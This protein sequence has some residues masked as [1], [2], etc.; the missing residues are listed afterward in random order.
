M[1]A[2]NPR[3]YH[4]TDGSSGQLRRALLYFSGW[5]FPADTLGVS[6]PGY[7]VYVVWDYT[8]SGED[9][10]DPDSLVADYDEV[11][12]VAWSFG[13]R[14][15]ADYLTGCRA[16]VTRTIAVNG[17]EAHVDDGRGIPH[18]IFDG[19]LRGLSAQT[20]Y[21]FMQRA[22]GSS[23]A[24]REYFNQIKP[25]VRE[26]DMESLGTELALFGRT[27]PLAGGYSWSVVLIGE[28]DRIFPPDNQRRAWAANTDVRTLPGADHYIPFGEIRRHIVDK[29]LVCSR[30]SNAAATYPGHSS[31]QKYVSDRLK[32][33]LEN[34]GTPHVPAVIEIGAGNSPVFGDGYDAISHKSLE[35]W[36]IA[37]IDPSRFPAGTKVSQTDAEIHIADIPDCSADL[38]VSA[39]T[40]QWFNSPE[41]F[42]TCLAAKLAPGGVAALAFYEPGTLGELADVTGITLRYP[43]LD[44]L[45]AVAREAG[46]EISAALSDTVT[47]KFDSPAEALRHLRLT[48]VNAVESDGSARAAALR[49]MRHCPADNDGK[50]TLTYRPAWLVAKKT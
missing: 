39:S 48:G 34:T 19:T 17:T 24:S 36:D 33:L 25:L 35:V 10:I 43:R 4:K 6:A 15:A 11:V 30:F 29:Q 3:R 27:A 42:V 5:G 20:F 8:D 38:V 18:A 22:C 12:V 50:V 2:I 26:A 45:A 23:A 41:R 49:F 40:I 32:A 13:V 28:C 31:V 46:L 9:A 16:R 47:L 37:A 1:T 21:K 14:V 7:D 44:R